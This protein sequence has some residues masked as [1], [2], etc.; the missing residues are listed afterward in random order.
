MGFVA[1]LGEFGF[2][3]VEFEYVLQIGEGGSG[4]NF[5]PKLGARG[6]S[7][8][9]VPE[10]EGPVGC[11][12]VVEGVEFFDFGFEGTPDGDEVLESAEL[13]VVPVI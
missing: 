3:A 8:H 2:F 6:T 13:E 5:V 4:I 12:A 11:G 10:A 1:D 9:V 7:L